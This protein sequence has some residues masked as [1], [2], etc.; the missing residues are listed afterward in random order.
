M[1]PAAALALALAAILIGVSAVVLLVRTVTGRETVGGE[2]SQPPPDA[3]PDVD[4]GA[5]IEVETPAGT[6]VG[7]GTRSA[8]SFVG[9]PYALP[10]VGEARFR[11]PTR[12]PRASTRIDARQA[13]PNCPQIPLG[14]GLLRAG[15]PLP[16]EGDEDCL[17]LDV[18]TRLD[19]APRPVM[20]YFHGGGFQRGG[21]LLGQLGASELAQRGDVVLVGVHY[22]LGALGMIALE[23]LAAES[24]T[25]STGNQGIRDQIAALEWVRDNIAALGGDPTR[26]TIFGESAGGESVCALVASPLARGLFVRAIS[27]SGGG[28]AL[29]PSL[30]EGQ[31]GR[32]SGF[33]RGAQIVAAAGCA[34]ASDIPACMRALD[35]PT[36]VRAGM[37]GEH[38]LHLP[39]FGPVLDGT[40]LTASTYDL[41]ARGEVDVPLIVGSNADE[42]SAFAV[43]GTLD[44]TQYTER[45]RHMAGADTDAAL[46]IWPATVR[47]TPAASLRLAI[48]EMLFVCPA[49]D[50][51]R[52]AAAGAYPAYAYR[53]QRPLPGSMGRR[54]GAFHGVELW[55]LFAPPETADR[56]PEADR[57]VV[58]TMHGAWVGFATS[59]TPITAPTWTPYRAD[60]PAIF[61]IDAPSSMVTDTSEGRCA[62]ARSAGIRRPL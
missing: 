9:V 49:E 36:L 13:G 57:A 39:T 12:A 30:R 62:Q 46:A 47:D 4:A 61:A 53:F 31:G 27:E 51:A 22:R 23:S 48:T 16:V 34:D 56:R 8:A 11:P 28:C 3:G 41:L 6:L 60:A 15:A 32:L 19:G 52:A 14:R 42:S 35:A 24:E 10:P 37:R 18:F 2:T 29:W 59:G 33:A 44:E 55:Y 43:L 50:L 25:G 40:V 5:D 17:R 26:V 38:H 1:K 45:V 7:T 58:D 54:F 20:V 21:Q